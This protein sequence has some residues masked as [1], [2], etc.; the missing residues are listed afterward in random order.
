[1]KKILI[2]GEDNACRSQ[3][4]EGW[5]RYYTKNNAEV[6]SAGV[7]ASPLDLNAAHAMS[8]AIIDISKQTS[9]ALESV[10]N[11]TYDF[12]LFVFTPTDL[13]AFSFNGTPKIVVKPFLRPISGANKKETDANYAKIQDEIENYCFDFVHQYVRKMY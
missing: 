4:A 12:V 3:M 10:V 11:E 6:T 8:Q 9:K 13:T 7:V 2:I 1:M 5:M